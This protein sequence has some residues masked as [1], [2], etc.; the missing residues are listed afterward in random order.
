MYTLKMFLDT[1]GGEYNDIPS[2]SAIPLV[3]SHDEN[4]PTL[5]KG[6]LRGY[7]RTI[8]NNSLYNQFDYLK[9]DIDVYKISTNGKQGVIVM[10]LENVPTNITM[11]L[12]V[13]NADNSKEEGWKAANFD[14]DS[15]RFELLTQ[16]SGNFYIVVFNSVTNTREHGTTNSSPY[17]L[18][19]SLDTLTGEN[20]NDPSTAT[21]ADYNS[22]I[23]GKIRGKYR[24]NYTN[25]N[26]SQDTKLTLDDDLYKIDNC[27]SFDHAR[28]SSSP[29][30][31][32]LGITALDA[33][34][35]TVLGSKT[36]SFAGDTVRLSKNDLTINKKPTFF[37]IYDLSY[38][39]AKNSS[40]IPY[41]FHVTSG[42]FQSVS[43]PIYQGS[44]V[45][46]TSSG[47]IGSTWTWN[48]GSTA[49]PSTSNLQNPQGVV[50]NTLGNQTIYLSSGTCLNEK[51]DI[52]VISPASISSAQILSDF[53][54]FSSPMNGNIRVS[55]NKIDNGD[56]I[57]HNTQGQLIRRVKVTNQTVVDLPIN[58]NGLYLVT[59]ESQ[60][61]RITKKIV[62]NQ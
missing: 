8:Y 21:K 28:I 6:K 39:S 1:L 40:P 58:S 20:N 54:A 32:Q 9:T 14:G 31:L 26:F 55:F 15:L 43:T 12:S 24:T 22:N 51:I 25:S 44:P 59:F 30:N 56:L 35:T 36:A 42:H 57:L 61:S 16:Y 62:I 48:F 33:D 46:F 17:T 10:K 38:N 19:L 4:N 49:T 34:G 41:T 37:L 7:Y 47:N 53:S 29:P 18:K 13:Y 60:E 45:N 3:I 50:F 52:N 2:G 27:D 5:L 23:K 11:G